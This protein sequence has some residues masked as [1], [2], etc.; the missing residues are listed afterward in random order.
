MPQRNL[1]QGH[2]L[3]LILLVWICAN[4]I[5]AQDN[6]DI[7]GKITG[8]DGSA[9]AFA[10][11]LLL[12]PSDSSLV[13]GTITGE[14]G[15]FEIHQIN[16]GKYVLM[17]SLVGYES[18]YSGPIEI[19]D[20][21]VHLDMV[22]REGTALEEVVVTDKKP[23][24]I[25]KIDRMVINVAQ[26]V[27]SA[28]GTAL[29]ILERSPGVTVNRQNS[30]VS[31]LGKDG[32]IMM[33]NGKISYMPMNAVIQLLDGMSAD[34]IES[35][36][37][38]TNPPANL[39]AEGNAGFINIEMIK[40]TDLGLQGSYSVSAGY[41]QDYRTSDNINLN[42]RSE[43]LN[44]FGNYS[45][46]INNAD[47]NHYVSRNILLSDQTLG[48]YTST[49]RDT[50]QRNH[51]IQI[52]ADYQ[53]GNTIFGAALNSY[54]NK[55]SMDALNQ[56]T[57]SEDGQVQ[58]YINLKNTEL[59][60][61]KHFGL[62]FNI[63]QQ[64]SEKS[65]ITGDLDYLLYKNNNPVDYQNFFYDSQ[66]LFIDSSL[67]RSSKL[68]PLDTWVGALDFQ[69]QPNSKLILEFGAK[70]VV[71]KFENDVRVEYLENNLWK[72]ESDL[73]SFGVLNEERY[74]AYGS[75]DFKWTTKTSIKAGLRY[76]YTDT[77]LDSDTEGNL[78]DRQFG[79][80]FPSIF[81]NHQLSDVL[82]MNLSYTKR[83]TR[84]TF[85]DL[86][87]FVILF[88]PNTFISG[89]SALQPAITNTFKYDINYKSI[90]FSLQYSHQDSSIAQFQERYDEENH[91]LIF[92][93]A[94]LDFTKTFTS[95]L[96]MAITVF[97]WWRMR[98]NVSYLYQQIRTNTYATPLTLAI[99]SYQANSTQ[100][101]TLSKVLSAE[102]VTF[103]NGPS[104]FG[105]AVY[106]S[107]YAVNLGLQYRFKNNAVL[108]FNVNDLFDSF[109]WRGGTTVKGEGLE[110]E[111][112]LDF[113]NRTFV[114]TYSSTFGNREVKAA[115]KRVRE[116]DEERSRVN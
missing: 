69:T 87:P 89:N 112:L 18:T 7:E 100:S 11:V 27:V 5:L 52:G 15:N 110:T 92:E 102:A 41:G 43:R 62:N 84:P 55:W 99:N 71:S 60:S 101:F 97:P 86:A 44:I 68:T 37:L 33:I 9:I 12:M 22:L 28:G 77:Q 30:S 103:I 45:F 25:Q 72:P 80:L 95:S 107:A 48:S 114:I 8:E 85:N 78:V 31:L 10:N 42:Y 34:N 70:T 49:F 35:I 6:Y 75:F 57:S 3:G 81:I 47:Q 98:N 38:I 61:W 67:S 36:E 50:R 88:D 4:S 108:R 64:L 66:Y 20:K 21:S 17:S 116:A 56:N 105:S 53:I 76:E 91:R 40:R 73:T 115:R 79:V 54:D 63:T 94:N 83:I 96:G 46:L 26:S 2:F 82:G 74:A 39:D 65:N 90:F 19:L 23:L 1:R 106:K 59:N 29:E 32:V 24:Y 113:Q 51:N 109:E 13:Q 58:S 104:F 16:P 93:S 14:M 111:N